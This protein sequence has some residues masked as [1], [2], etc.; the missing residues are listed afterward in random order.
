MKDLS[1]STAPEA[2]PPAPIRT[3]HLGLGAFFRAHQ[4]W[5]TQRANASVSTDEAYGTAAFTG[6]RP[7]AALPLQAQDGLYHV[8]VRGAEGDRTELIGSISAAY[9][10]AD[11]ATWVRTLADPA[12][13]T[14]TLTVTEAGYRRAADGGPNLDDP[15][16]AADLTR[17]R[18]GDVA[19]TTAPAR[20]VGGLAARRAADA[21]PIAIVPCD[22]LIDNG[23]TVRRVVVEL[24]QMVDPSLAEWIEQHVSFVST[25]IDRITPAT[26]PDDVATVADLTGYADRAPVVTEPFIEWVLA[27]DFPAGRP[28]WE[29]GGARFVDDVR[30][31]EQRKLWLLNGAHSLLAYAAPFRGHTTVATAIEDPVCR[32]WVESWWDAAA[33]HL[34][35]PSADIARYRADLLE[36]FANPRIR[37]NLAQI[38]MDGSQKLPIRALPVI[39]RERSAGR[40]PEAGVRLLGGW[41]AHLRDGRDVRDPRGS[42]FRAAASGPLR[43]ATGRMLDL[44]APDLAGDAELVAGVAEA[45]DELES[46]RTHASGSSP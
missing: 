23:P 17:L 36:R 1:R 35:L 12:V 6:R 45:A 3:A 22:N 27:G 42:E 38:A 19:L 39:I 16:V 30:P 8:L 44:L 46:G 24:A 32:G 11:G 28:P 9:D 7:D 29:A 26:T 41:L 4:A 21:G 14:L 18:P 20:I 5:Y 40:L 15:D 43:A 10:G 33:R 13:G 2:G 31:F 34:T 25:T 37:H